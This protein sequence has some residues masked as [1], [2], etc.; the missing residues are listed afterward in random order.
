MRQTVPFLLFNP[1]EVTC[2][3]EALVDFRGTTGGYIPEIELFK[4]AAFSKPWSDAEEMRDLIIRRHIYKLE[5]F[6][7]SGKLFGLWL[8][9]RC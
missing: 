4:N 1:E 7:V 5:K 2:S 6:C 3:S 9:E 8:P